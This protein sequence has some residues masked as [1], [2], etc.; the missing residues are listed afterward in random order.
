MKGSGQRAVVCLLSV[1][2]ALIVGCSS[3]PPKAPKAVK[4]VVFIPNTYSDFWKVVRKGTEKAD[5]ELADV[6]VNFQ[7]V[8]G[9]TKEEQNKFVREALER[10]EDAI[11]ISPIDPAGQLQVLNDPAKKAVVITQDSDA[12]Q[13]A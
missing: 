11:A 6:A 13:S 4:T 1:I 7:P 5:A 2:C 12:P 3:A 8:F 9:G 10:G